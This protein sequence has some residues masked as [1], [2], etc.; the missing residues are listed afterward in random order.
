MALIQCP[1]CGKE[2]SSRAE[3]CP[4]CGCPINEE[5]LAE[6]AARDGADVILTAPAVSEMP[7]Y[8]EMP[9]YSGAPAP[10]ESGG[11]LDTVNGYANMAMNKAREIASY[12]RVGLLEIDEGGKRFRI[13]KKV[14]RDGAGKKLLRGTAAVYTLGLS[15]A[16]EK[17]Y[18]KVSAYTNT[19]DAW[20]QFADLV[21]YHQEV[22]NSRQ[23]SSSGS[24]YSRK[25]ITS[26][27][28]QSTTKNVTDSASIVLNMN[29]L[30]EPVITIPFITKPVSGKE[31]EKI[32]IKFQETI[33]GLNY[34][35]TNK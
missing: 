21:S 18:K 33:V 14:N 3:A 11:V 23:Y 6:V 7:N 16:A 35:L 28:R 8:P 15:L 13:L 29:N 5:T 22:Q 17:A 25:G 31:F 4:F 30:D 9:S 19:S 26:R 2:I 27:S 20:Y 24:S 1:D 34:I 12:K 32:N 10:A